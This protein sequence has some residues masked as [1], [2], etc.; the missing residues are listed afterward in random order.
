[1]K[2]PGAHARAGS[3]DERLFYLLYSYFSDPQIHY[4]WLD[5]EIS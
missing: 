3:F 2:K 5:E 1:M 4:I